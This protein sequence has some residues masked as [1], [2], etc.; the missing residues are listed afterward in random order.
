MDLV[1]PISNLVRPTGVEQR[2]A[3]ALQPRDI[4]LSNRL[5]NIIGSRPSH[6]GQ[7]SIWGIRVRLHLQTRTI[8]DM[9]PPFISPPDPLRILRRPHSALYTDQVLDNFAALAAD[10]LMAGH[11]MW[12]VSVRVGALEDMREDGRVFDAHC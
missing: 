7:Q 3:Q 1:P 11:D 9:P 8:I 4:L 5:R 6:K 10:L 12:H 2:L